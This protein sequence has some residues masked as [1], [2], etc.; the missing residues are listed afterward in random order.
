MR[1]MGLLDDVSEIPTSIAGLTGDFRPSKKWNP[2]FLTRQTDNAQQDI[3]TGFESYIQYLSDVLYHTDDIMR[4]RAAERYFRKTYAPEDIKAQLEQAEGLRWMPQEDK[5]AFLRENGIITPGDKMTGQQAHQALQDYIDQ[6]YRTLEEKGKYSNLAPW[7]QNYANIL[8]GKQTWA[9]RG[10]ESEYGRKS[11]NVANKIMRMLSRSQVAGNISTVLNQTAQLPQ[12]IADAGAVNTAQAMRDMI[13]GRLRRT[14]FT[15]ESDFLSNKKG[16]NFLVNT[17]GEMVT[18]ALFKPA[19]LMD[20]MVSTLATRSGYLKAIKEGKSDADA[21]RYADRFAEKVMGSRAKGSRPL[22]FENKNILSQM[23]HLY[24]IEAMNS[25]E[26]LTQDL[27]RDFREIQRTQGKEKAAL[28]LAGV[29][30]KMLFSAFLLNRA[31]EETYG[32]TPAPYDILG[33][34]ANFI[35]SGEGLTANQWLL[36]VIDNGTEKLG[37]ERIF[38]TTQAEPQEF[39]WESALDDAKYQVMGDLPLVRNVAGIL[40]VGDQ[41]QVWSGLGDA[42]TNTGKAISEDGLFSGRTAEELFLLAAQLMPGGNQARKTYQGAKSLIQGGRVYGYGENARM[43]YP[44]ERTPGNIAR[45][46]LFGQ[47]AL[48]ESRE[49]YAGG[50]EG[51]LSAKQTG[52]LDDLVEAGAENQEAFE[53]IQNMKNSSRTTDKLMELAEA[54]W[55]EDVKEI[56]AESFMGESQLERYMAAR[57]ANVSTLDYAD[58]LQEAYKNA[59]D[60]TGKDDASPSQEDVK[61][62][63]NDTKLSRSQK[64]AIWKS[65]GWKTDSPW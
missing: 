48:P 16:I 4:I 9:D 46:L 26:H 41:T 23:V 27:P 58:F 10:M 19:E 17:P 43:Q 60:R 1:S 8:A 44:I 7:L 2:F 59:A 14:G 20:R 13:D 65:Y 25:W 40:G 57:K 62:A 49:F 33:L 36:Q 63:L 55:D 52:L 56:A 61:N 6:Q 38:G 22:A 3:A 45:G 50:A 18:S 11:L 39:D 47:S 24:Q 64:R 31:A 5:E 35:A 21:M 51:G 15:E 28:A 53:V 30:V 54:P 12:I 42:V 34:T 32:G 37:G 29:I